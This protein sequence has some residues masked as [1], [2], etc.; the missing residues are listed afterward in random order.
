MALFRKSREK[1][2]RAAWTVE[3]DGA[4]S[5]L[6]GT[7]HFFPYSFKT[8]LVRLVQKANC[9]LFEGPLDEESMAKVR[10]AGC[11]EH[12][13]AQLLDRLD[14]RTIAR[15][16]DVLT[17]AAPNRDSA[18]LLG[19]L[20]GGLASPVHSVLRDLKPWLAFFTVYSRYVKK[21][22]WDYSVDMEAYQVAQEMGKEIVFL[23][24]IQEQIEVLESLPEDRIL[25]FLMRI[26]H[27]KAYIKDFVEWYLRRDMESLK[28]NDY[29]FPTRHPDVI[30]RRDE[31][32]F[33]RL[34]PHLERAPVLACLGVPHVPGISRMFREAG[35]KVRPYHFSVM[36]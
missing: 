22:G 1:E 5:F 36:T 34:L 25:D 32:L 7:A 35:F 21:S 17:P 4:E 28:A 2:L 6:I 3:K 15:I 9:V 29:G 12:G 14:E 27:W 31:I 20:A 24:T 10:L 18:R 13:S 8:S 16:A 19:L 26:A 11:L 30:E 23:E 33:R